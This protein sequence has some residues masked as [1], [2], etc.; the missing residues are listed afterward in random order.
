M[1]I[2]SGSFALMQLTDRM[3]LTWFDPLAMGASFT[4]GQLPWFLVAFPFYIAGYTNA[5]ISQNNGAG[6][7]QEIAPFVWQGIYVGLFLFPLF[8]L[9]SFFCDIPFRLFR[10]SEDMI[11]LE[12]VYARILLYS[13]SAM[14]ANEALS[15]FFSGRKKMK[16]VMYVNIFSV[17]LNILLDYCFIFGINGYCC[18]GLAGAAIATS[19]SQWVR[20]F[21]Y[22]Y[23]IWRENRISTSFN[24]FSS[25]HFC[26]EKM[27][28]LI[29][30]GGMAGVQF[31]TDVGTFAFFICLLGM[32]GEKETIVSGIVF[33]L[34]G[35]AYMPI[36]GIGIA[37]VTMVGNRMGAQRPKLA[38]RATLTALQ[39]AVCLNLLFVLAYIFCPDFFLKLYTWNCPE[40]FE[41]LHDLTVVLLRYVSFYMLLDTIGIVFGSAI[42]GA[43]DTLFPMLITFIASPILVIVEL[44]GIINYGGDVH[45]CWS[46]L[47]LWIAFQC[48]AFT[49]RFYQGKWMKM[50]LL[51][52]VSRKGETV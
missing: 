20:F 38:K 24:F 7:L 45:W 51:N 30:K 46:A 23:L 48:V 12:E 10:H 49:L 29:K 2:S 21:T 3:F 15:S 39:L 33:N 13:A 1:V 4:G 50:Q 35:L 44:I 32:V 11:V 5:F 40:N 9:S 19:T 31:V 6:K 18:W 14:I 34:N 8:F 42:R 28:A 25:F 27:W 26:R 47:T 16:V 43:G 17:L 52:M 37:V 22:F 36:I 41:A